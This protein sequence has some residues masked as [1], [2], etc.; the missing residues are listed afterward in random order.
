MSDHYGD[1]RYPQ[2]GFPIRF[3]NSIIQEPVENKPHI[4]L[5]GGY[6]RVS[7]CKIHNYDLY[8][9]AHKFTSTLNLGIKL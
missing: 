3:D 5:S 2:E 7:K 9:K 8:N 6:W 4:K 1:L